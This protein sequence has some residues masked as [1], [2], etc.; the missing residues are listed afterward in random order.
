MTLPPDRQETSTKVSSS[1]QEPANAGP[2]HRCVLAVMSKYP[3]PGVVKTRLGARLGMR[4]ACEAHRR[5]LTH[6]LVALGPRGVGGND[7][8]ASTGYRDLRREIVCSPPHRCDDMQTL[9]GP[10]WRV[11]PQSDGDLGQRIEAWLARHLAP[12]TPQGEPAQNPMPDKLVLVGADCPTIS[13]ELLGEVWRRL[14]THDVV[15]VPAQDGGYVL[16]GL[17]TNR[18][19]TEPCH[20]AGNKTPEQQPHAQELFR[21]LWSNIDWGTDR[22]LQQ[23]LNAAQQA[24]WTVSLLPEEADV[25]HVED[26][27][28]VAGRLA[29]NPTP[30]IHDAVV[31]G[32]GIIGLAIAEELS[33]RGQSVVLVDGGMLDEQPAPRP[34]GTHST[35]W[36]AAG[37]LPAATTQGVTDPLDWLR[38][39]SHEQYPQWCRRLTEQAGI[40][41]GFHP[42]GGLY[43]A[44][45]RAEAASMTGMVA[46]WSDL[47]IACQSL[48]AATLQE[49]FPHLAAWLGRRDA[50]SDSQQSVAWYT[51]DEYQVRP[52]A[53]L[54]AL[55]ANCRK[56]RV[57][58]IPW[59]L[60]AASRE[61]GDVVE[62]T[63]HYQKPSDSEAHISNTRPIPESEDDHTKDSLL[64]RNLVLCGGAATGFIDES[65]KL[66]QAL[67]PVRGQMLLLHS[68]Q[69]WA[70][71]PAI[72]NAGQRYLVA[73][74]DGR[75]LVGSCEEEVGYRLGTTD[76]EIQRLRTFASDVVPELESAPELSRWSGLRPMTF[77]G[78]PIIGRVPHRKRTW[79]ASGHFRS[80]I[81]LA[82]GTALLMADWLI[83]RRRH[84]M[85]DAFGVGKQQRR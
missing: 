44:G 79:V 62:L 21:P 25:D 9:A 33:Q 7:C 64:T 58:M 30:V 10:G 49:R 35:S 55:A 51:P 48:D 38:G 26:W 14:N 31:V 32:G 43:L 63:I 74:G 41:T 68:E 65:L 61:R 23:T 24:G 18:S 17:S 81:H 27:L 72:I 67:I 52:P 73:R 16:I 2:R 4:R 8:D 28:E 15:L 83:H 57:D 70:Q 85:L 36:A 71:S 66:Q 77:D 5:M 60:A 19:S 39:I 20:H 34:D 59:A 53:L 3:T 75:V 11:V 47:G 56:N 42:C 29:P 50:K 84:P 80:G 54:E 82:C 37:I 69:P 6:L 78:M 1:I 22:V 13:Q 76:A 46:Y 12:P 40:E 45:S